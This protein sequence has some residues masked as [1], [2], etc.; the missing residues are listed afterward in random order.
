MEKC[1][2]II[3]PAYNAH[4]VIEK[5]LSSIASQTIANMVNVIIVNDNSIKDYSKSIEKFSNKIDIIELKHDINKGPGAARN[6]GIKNSSSPWIT[7][8][9]ADD[10]FYDKFSLE[11]LY[12]YTKENKYNAIYGQIAETDKNYKITNIIQ[13]EHFIWIMGSLFNRSFLEKQDIDFLEVYAGEDVSFNKKVKLLSKI[14]EIKFINHKI[15]LWTDA[16]KGQRINNKFFKDVTGKLAFAKILTPTYNFL[17]SKTLPCTSEELRYDF[18]SNLT[19]IFFLKQQMKRQYEREMI[20]DAYE[21]MKK[22]SNLYPKF[23]EEEM[24]FSYQYNYPIYNDN[25]IMYEHYKN[26]FIYFMNM[27]SQYT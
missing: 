24:L 19:S 21:Y 4:N 9:D 12:E 16:N 17:E 15:Y 14:E 13:A 2:D 27:V 23:T 3:I 18:L 5:A 25:Y 26:D 8:M 1:I 20:I 22:Y 10:V 11:I 6:T 7:F